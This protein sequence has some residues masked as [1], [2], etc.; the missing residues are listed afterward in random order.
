MNIV[1]WGATTSFNVF[2]IGGIESVINRLSRY[3]VQLGHS[4]TIYQID[5][6][7]NETIHLRIGDEFIT[8]M[9]STRKQCFHHFFLHHHDV[10]YFVQTP[11]ENAWLTFRYYI[12]KKREGFKTVKLFFTYPAH[13]GNIILETIKYRF[14]IDYCVAFSE[15]LRISVSK[16][17]K[18]NLRVYPPVSA[19]FFE[20][21]QNRTKSNRIRILFIGRLSHDKGL[22]VVISVFQKLNRKK[23]KISIQ[24]YFVGEEDKNRY[25]SA[26]KNLELDEL[27]IAERNQKEIPRFYEY[28]ILLLPYQQ[29][30]PTLDTPLIL[31]EGLAAGC[32]II[33]SFVSIPSLFKKGISIVT[34]ADDVNAYVNIL[35]HLDIET[36]EDIPTISRTDQVGREL[37][38]I[39]EQSI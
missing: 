34:P 16:F 29:S 5:S 21:R 6:E 8:V 30:K 2:R 25:L 37:L 7:I 31:L 23:F 35:D 28:D 33:T 22:D 1:F 4:V 24:G 11:F 18:C 20:M 9:T 14:L 36:I 26:L 19:E 39:M 13:R 12:K 10:I 15:R 17:C 3:F 32:L 38:S 27:K